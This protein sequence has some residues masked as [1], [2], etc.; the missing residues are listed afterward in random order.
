MTGVGGND[1]GSTN[2]THNS[3][4]SKFSDFANADITTQSN[5]QNDNDKEVTRPR[6]SPP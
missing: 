5:A 2:S 6:W 4:T 1:D 3:R